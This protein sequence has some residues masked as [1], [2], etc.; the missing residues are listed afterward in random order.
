[1]KKSGTPDEDSVGYARP[2]KEFQ[3]RSG[4]SGNSK[5][6][7][8]RALAPEK[9]FENALLQTVQIRVGG[10][11]VKARIIDVIASQ[12]TNAAARG[13]IPSANLALSFVR[14]TEPDQAPEKLK[15]EN[16][17]DR[18]LEALISRLTK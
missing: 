8:K 2:P 17:T 6:R 12:I 4:K 14:P 7:P 10:R 1:M 16:L 9:A 13:H 18:Q 3:F 15:V 11:Q 5:G